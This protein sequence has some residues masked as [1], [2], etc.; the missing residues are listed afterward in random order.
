MKLKQIS[1]AEINKYSIYGV[2]EG[3][4]Y[5]ELDKK[6]G[7]SM[8]SILA[9]GLYICRTEEFI[10]KAFNFGNGTMKDFNDYVKSNKM[11]FT[12]LELI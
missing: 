1:E 12:M 10:R 3:T 8:E 4:K 11:N 5:I 2:K 7:W 6:I 9:E